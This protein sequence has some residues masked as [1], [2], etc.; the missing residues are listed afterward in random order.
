MAR[1][2][3]SDIQR[4]PKVAL[5]LDSKQ[6]TAFAGESLATVILANDGLHFNRTAGDQP[7]AAYCNMG[8]CFECQ[9]RVALEPGESSRWVRACMAQALEGMVVVT[10]QSRLS[11][12]GIT[13]EN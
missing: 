13:D 5:T 10:G 6:V 12:A 1:N 9:V 11:T 7:R 8:T 3:S 4:G 2:P